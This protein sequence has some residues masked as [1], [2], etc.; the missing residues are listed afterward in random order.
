MRRHAARIGATLAAVLVL[1]ACAGG[2][3]ATGPATGAAGPSSG[4]D[5]P[6]GITRDQLYVRTAD[7]RT[8]PCTYYRVEGLEVLHRCG[9]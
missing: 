1:S 4:P 8:G 9:G 7:P 6:P 2:P 5:L 3:A